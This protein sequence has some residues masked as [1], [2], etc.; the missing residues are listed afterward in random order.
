MPN[1]TDILNKKADDI[2]KPPLPPQGT[3][4]FRVT[5]VPEF[6]EV[7]NGEWDMVIIPV[8]AVEAMDNVDLDGYNGDVSNIRLSKTF[9]F[10]KND[11]VGFAQTQYQFRQFLEH[12]AGVLENNMKIEEALNKLV[13]AEFL[14]DV[15][16]R[17]DN[18]NEGEFIAN[19]AKTAP[20]D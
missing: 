7:G 8:V 12:H 13:G 11:E 4:R 19:I 20:V 9:L 18:R 2:E 16:W 3:Y 1:F 15:V 6:K 5:K 10:S 17:E 14:G